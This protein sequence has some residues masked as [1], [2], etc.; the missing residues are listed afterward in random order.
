MAWML[1][2]M[3][4]S[5]ISFLAISEDIITTCD[6][7]RLSE[8]MGGF[9]FGTGENPFSSEEAALHILLHREL[10]NGIFEP[11]D[12][13]KTYLAQTIGGAQS[14]EEAA[15][16]FKKFV[17]FLKT[18]VIEVYFSAPQYLTFKKKWE[19][20]LAIFSSVDVISALSKDS[21]KLYTYE[22]IF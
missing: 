20:D 16:E 12:Q 18:D 7:G 4:L 13:M 9:N 21:A 10:K 14:L 5:A 3:A 2:F 8:F 6:E 22:L 17:E 1:K 11:F 19:K 15:T